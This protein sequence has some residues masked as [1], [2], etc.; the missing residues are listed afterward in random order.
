[1]NN[2]YI[3]AEIYIEE[4]DINKDIRII[5]SFEQCKREYKWK[6]NKEDKKL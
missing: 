5:N 1:M 6:D 4:K 3:Y 2:N